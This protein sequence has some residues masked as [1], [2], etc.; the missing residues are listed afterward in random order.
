M[1]GDGFSVAAG[2]RWLFLGYGW[3]WDDAGVWR[4]TDRAKADRDFMAGRH[5]DS[6]RHEMRPHDPL[7]GT[8]GA[9]GFRP[10]NLPVTIVC[11]RCGTPQRLD[12]RILDVDP[13]LHEHK[14]T[15]REAEGEPR[16][17]LEDLLCCRN[18]R[19]RGTNLAAL[20]RDRV[21]TP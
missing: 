17:R 13:H 6:R 21:S 12:A 15:N 8:D 7:P 14:L 5:G 2:M 20:V 10:H 19:D 3:Q 1:L 18:G 9:F 11:P 4:V 16:G